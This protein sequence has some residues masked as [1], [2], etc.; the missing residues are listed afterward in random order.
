MSR[1]LLTH[2][3]LPPSFWPNHLLLFVLCVAVSRAS[4]K[5]RV[6]FC[7]HLISSFLKF[8]GLCRPSQSPLGPETEI[9]KE[10]GSRNSR[11]WVQKPCH[12]VRR[13]CWAPWHR[14]TRRKLFVCPQ[15]AFHSDIK[16]VG[17]DAACRRC[18]HKSCYQIIGLPHTP[19]EQALKLYS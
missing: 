18:V 7:T 6:G 12:T 10:R 11:G 19:P 9:S 2:N 8:L 1:G 15:I 4:Q 16:W 5:F 3:I 17:S 13:L 14:P